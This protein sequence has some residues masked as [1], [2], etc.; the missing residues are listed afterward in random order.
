MN[1]IDDLRQV[2]LDATLLAERGARRPP[3]RTFNTTAANLF[4]D[5]IQIF[6]ELRFGDHDLTPLGH[7]PSC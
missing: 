3:G 2:H 6:A 4:A 1:R 5:L 7:L